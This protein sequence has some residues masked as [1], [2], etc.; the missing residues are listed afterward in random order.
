MLFNNSTLTELP[1]LVAE[2]IDVNVILANVAMD[3]VSYP[4]PPPRKS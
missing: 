1:C 2:S 4:V 3:G